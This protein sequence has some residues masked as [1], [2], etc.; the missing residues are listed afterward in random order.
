AQLRD[1]HK[2]RYKKEGL[3]L[4]YLAFVVAATARALR[5]YPEL[6]ARVLDDSFVKLGDVN[7]GIAVDTPK[8]LV[9]PVIRNADE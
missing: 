4:T 9:V 1:A 6:N 5:E 2:G 8:G 3:S 7:L